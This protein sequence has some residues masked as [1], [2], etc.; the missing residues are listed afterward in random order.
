MLK[1]V[2]GEVQV[3]MTALRAKFTQHQGPRELLLETSKLGPRVVLMEDAPHDYIWCALGRFQRAFLVRRR[4]CANQAV[5]LGLS[6]IGPVH[7]AA[8]H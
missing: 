1:V 2:T 3:M 7:M 4:A 5:A 6:D 8:F